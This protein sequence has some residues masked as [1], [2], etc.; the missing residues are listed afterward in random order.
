MKNPNVVMVGAGINSLVAANYLQR[1]GCYVTMI[2]RAE[3]VGGACISATADVNGQKQ[4]YALGASVLGLMQDFVFAE[5]GLADRLQTYVPEDPKLIYCP[6]E[7][8]PTRIFRDPAELDRELADRWGER[9]AVEA[10][11]ADE[12]RVVEY[13]QKG[14]V[15]ARPPTLTEARSVL[16]E[17]LTDLWISGS[18]ANLMDHY[19][20]SDKSKIYMAMTITE[21]GPVSLHEPYS[22]FTLPLMDSGSIFGGYYGFVKGGIWRITEMLGEINAEIGVTT[23][24]SG[25]VVEVD[26]STNKVTFET[27]S[28]EAS[29]EY[30]LLV[31][32]T[33]PLTATRLVGSSEELES[34]GQMR[35]RGSSGK[36]NLMFEKP[37]RWKHSP[38]SAA[39]FRFI[40]DVDT[41][42]DFENAAQSVIDDTVDY[43]PGYMQ[44]YC[45]GAAMRKLK[46]DD[47]FDRLAVFFKNFSLASNGDE[48]PDVEEQ[49]KQKVLALIDN[50]EDCAWSRM[51]TPK[52]L[53]ELFLFPGGNLDHTMLAEGQTFFERNFSADA[54]NNFYRFGELENVFLCASG[55]YPCGSVTGTPGYMCAKQ[56]LRQ[57]D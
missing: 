54:E 38:E 31:L 52:D 2:E 25:S 3:K 9:G 37:V 35:F 22:A 27:G 7:T 26:K 42:E 57:T 14:Y 17:T 5:T 4:D 53:Q 29:I 40:F 43:E 51:L 19:F 56:I 21:S 47:P 39:A 33:D 18:A 13:L 28:N 45:E 1:A 8:E 50:P 36:L 55:T 44:I 30:D 12:G 48:L 10:F 24:L 49:A 23:H 16:G 32:G 34:T 41:L 6:D 15:E 11:R 20:T 46:H